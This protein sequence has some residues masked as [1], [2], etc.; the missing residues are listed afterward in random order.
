MCRLRVCAIEATSAKEAAFPHSLERNKQQAMKGTTVVGTLALAGS[1]AAFLAPSVPRHMRSTTQVSKAGVGWVGGGKRQ[2]CAVGMK[3]VI[4]FVCVFVHAHPNLK[5][6][7]DPDLSKS[8]Y[9]WT[10]YH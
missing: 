6:T 3:P 1:A 8:K 10:K 4:L 7:S 5:R 9:S 2:R